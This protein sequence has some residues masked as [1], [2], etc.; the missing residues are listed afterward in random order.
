LESRRNRIKIPSP[1]HA[2]TP[3]VSRQRLL[4]RVAALYHQCFQEDSKGKEYLAQVGLKNLSVLTE[5]Q[6]GW[7]NGA[8]LATIP[9]ESELQEDLRALGLL[10]GQGEVLSGCVVFPWFNESGDCAGLYGLKAGSGKTVVIPG[11]VTGVWNWQ[12][13]KRGRSVILTD[14]IL[15]ALYLSQAGF[16]EVLWVQGQSLTQDH[17]RLFQRCGTKEIYLTFESGAVLAQLKEEEVAA[18]AVKLP[19][20]PVE[21]SVIEWALKEANGQTPI[22][23]DEVKKRE[24]SGLEKN[25]SGFSI[26]YGKRRYEIKGV[27]KSK[28]KLKVTMKA[29]AEGDKRF[30]LDS[31]DLYSHR[32]RVLFA[33]ACGIYFGEEAELVQDDLGKLVEM[34]ERYEPEEGPKAP[35]FTMTKEQ[36]GEALAFLKDPQLL[37]RIL[38]DFEVCGYTGE[39]ANKLMG[40]LAAVSRKLEDPLS[41][42]VQSRSAAGKSTLQDAVLRF[43]PREDFEKYTRLTGQALFYKDENGLSHKLLAIEEEAGSREASYSIRNLQSA[44]AL[45]IATTGKD[46]VTGKLKTAE[47]QVKG[48]VAL[49]LTTTSVDMDYETQNRFIT[50][51]IDESKEMTERIL[52]NQRVLETLEGMKQRREQDKVTAKHQNAQRLLKPLAVVNPYATKLTFPANTLRARRDHKKYLGII[53]TI[54]FLHQ[55]QREIKTYDLGETVS[56]IEVELSDIEKANRLAGEVLG[57]TVGELSAPS[58]ALLGIIRDMVKAHAGPRNGPG[59]PKASASAGGLGTGEG[60]SYRFTRRNIREFSGWSDFQVKTHIQELTDLEYLYSVTGKKGKEYIY[61]LVAADLS[62]GQVPNGHGGDGKP[63]LAGLTK[64]EAL[65]PI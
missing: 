6:T 20:L 13:L 37:D 52:S 32:G 2:A 16:K 35:V 64:V 8:L 27:E 4:N 12:A 21:P 63:F 45:S 1:S 25:E 30:Y 15:D 49:M 43:V 17:L 34:A 39:E 24:P 18:Y 7:V 40:Y 36:E 22:R 23:S 5:F 59:T 42:L 53:K 31:V 54:A 56:Y 29:S 26:Q 19:P 57:Q 47:Y 62:D 3:E 48:P 9:E 61:E 10:D 51:T 65:N 50:L 41:V 38:E 11:L 28:T 33:K 44:K 14:G 46:P 58:R 60:R 55:Y